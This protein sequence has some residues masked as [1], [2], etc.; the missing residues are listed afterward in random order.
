METITLGEATS[1]TWK[2]TGY[3]LHKVFSTISLTPT[4]LPDTHDVKNE[5]GGEVPKT[6]HSLKVR[7]GEENEKK[8]PHPPIHFK[9]P[10][11][12]PCQW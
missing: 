9:S 10:G 5:E 1:N 8:G 4:C 3:Q 2:H 11:P 12:Q 7:E 6:G